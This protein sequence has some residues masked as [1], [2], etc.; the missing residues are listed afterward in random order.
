V[1]PEPEAIRQRVQA[2]AGLVLALGPDLTAG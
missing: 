2:G 1:I